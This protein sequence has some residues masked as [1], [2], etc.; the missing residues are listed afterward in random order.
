MELHFPTPDHCLL[1]GETPRRSLSFRSIFFQGTT[2]ATLKS[3]YSLF[4]HSLVKQTQI[5]H[6]AAG[7]DAD[8]WAYV[9]GRLGVLDNQTERV[10]IKFCNPLYGCNFSKCPHREEDDQLPLFD[11]QRVKKNSSLIFTNVYLT[12]ETDETP[13]NAVHFNSFSTQNLSNLLL[14]E[15][16]FAIHILS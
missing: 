3:N 7:W 14:F 12:N 6:F 15:F 5:F 1:M 4:P 8:E 16:L 2:N 9:C 11:C 13:T 10:P